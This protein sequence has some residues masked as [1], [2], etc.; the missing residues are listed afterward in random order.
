[1]GEIIGR[2]RS[3][4]AH[5]ESGDTKLQEAHA[6]KLDHAWEAGALFRRLVKFAKAGHDV[7]WFKTHLELEARA[8]ELRIWELGWIPGLLQ[9][10]GYARAMFEAAGVEDVE[11]G[12]NSRLNRQGCLHRKPR[13]RVWVILDQGVIEQPVG[14]A[15]VMREQLARLV[16]V[17]RL[18]HVTIRVVPRE[19]GAHVGRDGSFK[20]ITA[21]GSDVVYAAAHS[22]GRLVEDPTEIASYRVWFDLI[23]DVALPKDASLRFLRETLE[24]F[25]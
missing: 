15:D 5:V 19:V 1:M 10:E 14:S 13:P 17:A 18:P 2:D 4:V 11:E 22:G 16:E 7:E 20:I 3:L 12:V 21:A 24:R 9:T 25:S 8:S 23:G 6:K